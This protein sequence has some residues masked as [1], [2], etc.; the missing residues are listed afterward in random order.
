MPAGRS[1]PETRPHSAKSINPVH[2]LRVC[3]TH[4]FCH[5]VTYTSWD[6]RSHPRRCRLRP[7]QEFCFLTWASLRPGPRRWPRGKKDRRG[8]VL[9]M[10]SCCRTAT[11]G[12]ADVQAPTG[13]EAPSSHS[14]HSGES[15]CSNSDSSTQTSPSQ[16]ATTAL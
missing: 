7:E 12:E 4:F 10:A 1:D 6:L 14:E 9:R 2:Y 16:D 11:S 13:P 8:Q 15:G 3:P 5:S